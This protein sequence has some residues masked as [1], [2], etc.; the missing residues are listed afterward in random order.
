MGKTREEVEGAK[1]NRRETRNSL[2]CP[3]KDQDHPGN[4]SSQGSPSQQEPNIA[5]LMVCLTHC[6]SPP[7]PLGRAQDGSQGQV[8]LS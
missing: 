7:P 5:L 2:P 1:S 4:T 6:R 3:V 8:K